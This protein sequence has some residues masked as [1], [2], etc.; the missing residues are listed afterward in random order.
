MVPNHNIF[1][2]LNQKISGDVYWDPI[3]V[4]MLSSGEYATFGGMYGTNASGAQSVKYGNVADYILDAEVVLSSGDVFTLSNILERPFDHLPDNLKTLF[5]LYADQSQKIE[6][7]YPPIRYNST[8]YNLRGLVK[9]DRLDLSR[10]FAGSE[11]TL[12]II[13]RLKFKLRRT[14]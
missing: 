12:G 1:S 5:S 13:T 14:W 4:Y 2:E 6:S 9:N 3:R 8:G 11:G 10:L 7:S